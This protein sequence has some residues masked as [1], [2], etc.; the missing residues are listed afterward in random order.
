MRS[1][2]D[3]PNTFEAKIMIFDFDGVIID[4]MDV[5]VDEYKN[6][7][8]QFTKD[9]SILNEIVGIYKNSIGIP[10]EITL[11]KVLEKP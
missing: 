9:E 4:S 8:S 7:F 3:Y 2:Q 11:K 6:L 5:K 10:R 1:S